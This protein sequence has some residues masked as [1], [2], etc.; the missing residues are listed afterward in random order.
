M[1]TSLYRGFKQLALGQMYP[2]ATVSP[3]STR[4]VLHLRCWLVDTAESMFDHMNN[5]NFFKVGELA[6]WR[7]ISESG[8][9][10]MMIK[11]KTMLMAAGQTIEYR[12][13]IRNFQKY[14][15]GTNIR[16]SEDD[17]WI[18]FIH[19]FE[20]EKTGKLLASID[21]R[22]VM[23]AAS[24]KTIRP[25]EVIASNPSYFDRILQKPSS[26]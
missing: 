24:G 20:D 4:S 1:L 2:G 12:R 26:S 9:L 8:V 17:K 21:M 18:H 16:I 22:M 25:S 19:S 7:V 11:N 5:A 3:T 10:N 23:K 14:I 6:R 15:I 13:P